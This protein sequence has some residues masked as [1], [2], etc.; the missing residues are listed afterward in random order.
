MYNIVLIKQL[1]LLAAG[2]AATKVNFD[3]NIQLNLIGERVY[4]YKV[5]IRWCKLCNS[6]GLLGRTLFVDVTLSKRP[7]TTV[8]F[9]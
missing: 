2:S 4:W 3:S 6:A 9:N 1:I 5:G 7:K 8:I